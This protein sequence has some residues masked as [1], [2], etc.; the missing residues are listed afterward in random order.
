MRN[1]V[2]YLLNGYRA[3][4]MLLDEAQ[5]DSALIVRDGQTVPLVAEI[6]YSCRTRLI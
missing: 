1:G 4:S 3:A 5:L 2:V 6:V